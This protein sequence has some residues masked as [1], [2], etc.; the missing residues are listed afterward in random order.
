MGFLA[1]S[2]LQRK[3]W[4]IHINHFAT[5]RNFLGILQVAEFC[6]GC[7]LWDF[8]GIFMGFLWDFRGIF[9][10]FDGILLGFFWNVFLDGP[11]VGFLWDCCG[12]LRDF[13]GIFMECAPG[14]PQKWDFYGFFLG[15][16]WDC[17]GSFMGLLWEF[18]DLMRFFFWICKDFPGIYWEIS[19]IYSSTR[20]FYGNNVG[21][22]WGPPN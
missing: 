20:V 4:K 3:P 18:E 15:F 12:I 22:P 11:K 5:P 7:H 19:G 8:Y 14:W 21:F 16:S 10:G 13:N 2:P 1:V 9:V 6:L 17:C